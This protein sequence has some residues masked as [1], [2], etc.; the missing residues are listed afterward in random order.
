MN[1][2]Q[3]NKKILIMCTILIIIILFSSIKLINVY[4]VKKA[5]KI[6]ELKTTE[7]EVYSDI[8]LK[9]LISNINGKII[10][11][12]KIDTKKLGKK[13]ITFE[14]INDDNIKI[15]YTITINVVDKTPPIISQIK[16]Y[17]ITEG[18]TTDISKTLFCG[19]NYD[20]NPKC[21]IKGEYDVNTPGT[22]NVT[23][24]GVDSSNNK[25]TNKMNIIV[26][27]KQENKQSKNNTQQKEPVYT[28]Y[29][30][31]I[32]NYKTS[33]NEIGIDVSHWQGNINYKKVKKSGVEFVYIRVGRGDGIGEG[34]VLDE[35]FIKNIKG[36][37]K[38]GIPVGVYFYSNANNKN[39]AIKEAKWVINQIK[40]Y[41][42]SLEI[43][44]DW[45]NW[46]KFQDYNL[47]FY[48]LT[49]TANA[50]TETVEK[51]GYKGMVYSSKNYLETI[52][53]NINSDIWLAHYT[54]KTDYEK[55]YKVWQLCNNGKV[56]GIEDNLVDI[57]IRY[58]K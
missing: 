53:Y 34:Y 23:F 15:N 51:A 12:K 54:P 21:T 57:N 26:E 32:K 11:N 5:K 42:V 20:K 24:I 47:S 49:E 45:E 30:D 27:E 36:F 10:D 7:V 28:D 9:D 17:K 43:V 52:W 46:S 38:V 39:D 58:K 33:D 35:K 40:K 41:D 48:S 22:Y 3:I 25:S 4:K 56:V 31:V 44:F 37:N 18:D 2:E 13:E 16:N 50:F 55:K 6:V 29:K 14:Y 8:K 1:K 19:D